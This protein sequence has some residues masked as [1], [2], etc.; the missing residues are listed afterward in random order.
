MTDAEEPATTKQLMFS[1]IKRFI[2]EHCRQCGDNC[3]PNE[4]RIL[5]CVLAAL[6][7]TVQ[8]NNKLRREF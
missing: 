2:F 7:D 3:N 5:V 1:P 4:Q 8:R 6:L